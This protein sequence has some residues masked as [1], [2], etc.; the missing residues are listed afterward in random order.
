M[1]KTAQSTYWVRLKL[2]KSP[3]QLLGERIWEAYNDLDPDF[4]QHAIDLAQDLTVEDLNAFIA[5]FF[6]ADHFTMLLVKP[7][8]QDQ[9]NDNLCLFHDGLLHFFKCMILNGM[10]LIALSTII[11]WKH[12]CCWP[13]LKHTAS[14][15]FYTH[16]R[17]TLCR[18]RAQCRFNDNPS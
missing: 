10:V 4:E 8:A 12:C 15:Q 18:Q 7:E 14:R 16:S 13:Q 9:Q 6:N 2:S 3:N 1:V 11:T 17:R 5:D